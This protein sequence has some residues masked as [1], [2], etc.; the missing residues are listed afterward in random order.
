MVAIVQ[1]DGM[2]MPLETF[3][4]CYRMVRVDRFAMPTMAGDTRLMAVDACGTV[5]D[6]CR[7]NQLD[8]RTMLAFRPV[9]GQQEHEP[10]FDCGTSPD[11]QQFCESCM[12]D[13]EY[14]W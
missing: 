6:D 14:G 5:Y 7:A 3:I 2:S 11:E 8:L 10:C 9:D 13:M 12:E 4:D 1:H